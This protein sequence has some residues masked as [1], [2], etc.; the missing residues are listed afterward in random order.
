MSTRFEAVL[1]SL[2]DD[3]DAV[4]KGTVSMWLAEVGQML[5]EGD[6]LLEITTDKAAFVVPSPR[7]GALLERHVAEG[8]VV[9]V[10]QRIAVLDVA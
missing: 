6:D 8:E 4:T 9:L 7:A 2:G 5:K 1:P 3:D 10:G